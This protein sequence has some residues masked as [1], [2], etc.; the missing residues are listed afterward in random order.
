MRRLYGGILIG[1]AV[2]GLCFL[3]LGRQAE[4]T[5]L[6]SREPEYIFTYAENQPADYPTARAAQRFGELVKEKTGGRIWIRL[7]SGGSQ[8]TEEEVIQQLRFGGVDFA[9]ISVMSLAEEVPYM[10]VLQLPYLYRDSEHMWEVLDGSIGDACMEGLEGYGLKGMAWYDAGA[11]HIYNSRKPIERLEDMNGLKIRIADSALMR[12]M[13]KA[14]GAQ[15]VSMDYSQVYAALQTGE[16]DGAENN[17]PSY[18]TMKHYETAGYITLTAHNR[19]P[20]LQ[21][22]S[23]ETWNKLSEEDQAVLKECAGEAALYERRLWN[24]QEEASLEKMTRQG[25]HVTVLNDREQRRFHAMAATVYKYY[26][27]EYE[28]LLEQI[29]ETGL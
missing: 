2:M 10:N 21:L 26:M 24:E 11:R 13:I 27:K 20:E 4:E 1:T 25:C 28:D 14:L 15:P 8:G 6:L 19:I 18:D 3:V 7:C 23:E 22:A 16:I 12:N 9:R 29:Q 17:W 5:G